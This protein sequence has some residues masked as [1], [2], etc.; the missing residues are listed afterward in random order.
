M[1]E[2]VTC[3][4]GEFRGEGI[5]KSVN[6]AFADARTDISSQIKSSITGK[7]ERIIKQLISEGNKSLTAEWIS[8]VVLTTELRN[9]QDVKLRDTRR[10][11][12]QVG[13]VACMSCADAAKPYKQDQT[14]LQDSLEH[15]A[16]FGLQASNPSSK[17]E[18]R[19]RVNTLWYQILNNQEL[20]KSWG[21]EGDINKAKYFRDAVE[22]DYKDY[23]QTAKL[24]WNQDG[25]NLYSDMAF[26][27]LSLS[28][29]LE[30]EKSPCVGRGISLIYKNA[31]PVCEFQGLN[32]CVS[33]P[34]LI[35]SACDGTEYMRLTSQEVGGVH[36]KKDVAEERLQGKLR[37]ES[38]WS[39]WESK[40]LEWRPLCE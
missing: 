3:G 34:I 1:L 33:R 37:D 25:G 35:I 18:A 23:C 17:S 30:I 36:N 5:G 16:R 2:P 29:K 22:D 32:R 19:R 38:F 40:I 9:A 20:L 28:Q 26:S 6:E 10:L 14:Q 12:E 27:K 21:M 4:A 13:V 15:I 39:D 7:N 11:G 8:E 24:H 31:E